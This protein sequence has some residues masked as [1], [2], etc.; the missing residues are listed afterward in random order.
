MN[1]RKMVAAYNLHHMESEQ[2]G[3]LRDHGRGNVRQKTTD[4]DVFQY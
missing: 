1:E 4:Q 2:S 3:P